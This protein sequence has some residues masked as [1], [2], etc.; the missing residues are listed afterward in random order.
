MEVGRT[1]WSARVP[2]DPLFANESKLM[3]TSWPTRASAADLGIR[4]T[5]HPEIAKTKW[6]CP[7]MPVMNPTLYRKECARA[8]RFAGLGIGDCAPNETDRISHQALPWSLLR[9]GVVYQLN[10]LR[11]KTRCPK[12]RFQL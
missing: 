5:Q 9:S 3:R 6:H 12:R 11:F 8:V 10:E 7:W 1:P 2:P 4:P